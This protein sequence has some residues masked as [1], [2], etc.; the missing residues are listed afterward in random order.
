MVR[1]F[2]Q[3]EISFRLA[4]D[5][6]ENDPWSLVSAS[7]GLAFCDEMEMAERLANQALGVGLGASRLHW[8]YQTCVRFLAGDFERTVEYADRAR[9]M[10][11]GLPAWKAAALFHLGRRQEAADEVQRFLSLVRGKWVG[12]D[13][14]TDETIMR[15]FLQLYPIRRRRQWQLLYDGLAGAGAPMPDTGD[16]DDQYPA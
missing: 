7:L 1:Y 11:L 3:A 5:L 8:G 4:C 14:A 2:N 12:G 13:A 6:N 15:W 9:D 10:M 16:F